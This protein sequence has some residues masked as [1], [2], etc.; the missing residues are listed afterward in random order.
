MTVMTNKTDRTI[1]R[2]IAW[3]FDLNAIAEKE[4]RDKKE[5]RRDLIQA[6]GKNG[7]LFT[8]MITSTS[9]L[10]PA[11]VVFQEKATKQEQKYFLTLKGVEKEM[12]YISFKLRDWIDELD[13]PDFSYREETVEQEVGLSPVD[14][15]TTSYGGVHLYDLFRQ[16]HSQSADALP[17]LRDREGEQDT[18]FLVENVQFK[19]FE[20]TTSN[21][22]DDTMEFQIWAESESE[23]KSNP[24]SLALK[25]IYDAVADACKSINMEAPKPVCKANMT[26]S[27]VLECDISYLWGE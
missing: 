7:I 13:D 21:Y 1:F 26:A 22:S 24:T 16:F 8:G 15:H 2:R 25:A 19:T 20:W 12:T 11:D 3:K 6:L 23:T 10:I 17:D 14:K 5:V 4:G 9:N 18:V 27:K